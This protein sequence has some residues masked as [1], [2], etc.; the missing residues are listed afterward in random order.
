MRTKPFGLLELGS[1]SLKFYRVERAQAETYRIATHKLPWRIA[2]VFFTG[3]TLNNESV[4]EILS[5]LREVKTMA[6]DLQ[7]SGM[8]SLATGVFREISD[9][10]SLADRIKK[11]LGLRLRVISGKDE[12]KLMARGF[13][14]KSSGSVVL[15]DLGG[16]TTE[17]AWIEGGRPKNWGS[18]RLGAIRNLCLLRKFEGQPEAYLE[19]GRELCDLEL[20]ALPVETK[21]VFLVTGG[22]A[23]ALADTGG[24]DD[25]S[26]EGLEAIIRDVLK[27]GP[28]ESLKP[29]RR[30]VY[31]PGLIILARMMA[32]CQAS[33]LK[34]SRTSVREGMASRLVDLLDK[35]NGRQDLHS[36]L[37][38]HT[39]GSTG[40]G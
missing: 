10:G 9:I 12:A 40:A 22:T 15:G 32:R 8:L 19:R 33:S 38:L 24:S 39:R 30:E 23:K 13:K 27:G 35:K 34:Y 25:I 26:C 16:A 36:T 17:W 37:L 3:Q 14:A 18:L 28:P 29:S 21:S 31:L 4:E 5:A 20:R 2:H 6:A 11:E 7:L 1:N